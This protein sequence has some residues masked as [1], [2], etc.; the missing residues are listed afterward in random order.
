V[1][2]RGRNTEVYVASV[3]AVKRAQTHCHDTL[4][5]ARLSSRVP[6]KTAK[7]V[8]APEMVDEIDEELVGRRV[9]FRAETA[10]SAG[11]RRTRQESIDQVKNADGVALLI[12]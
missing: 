7:L 4:E 3:N 6:S 1:L 11:G 12:L 10:G 8:V 5:R 2:L 9:S